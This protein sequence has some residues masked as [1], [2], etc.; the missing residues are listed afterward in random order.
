MTRRVVVLG[1]SHMM[2]IAHAALERPEFRTIQLLDP[3][4]D[5]VLAE[6]QINQAVIDAF[7]AEPFDAVA[8]TLG[9]NEH[10]VLGLV[11][12]P[13]P[14]DFTFVDGEDLGDAAS[15]RERVPVELVRRAIGRMLI[16]SRQFLEKF[17]AL[18]DAPMYLL[19]PPPPIRSDKHLLEYGGVF[20]KEM[21]ARGIAP[22]RLRHK[23]WTLQTDIYADMAA[24]IGVTYLRAPPEA[25]D[26]DGMLAERAWNLDATHANP[27]YGSLVLE[28][29]R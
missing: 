25:I 1:H 2:A 12:H 10:V 5:P 11:E 13:Q 8:L 9:G 16:Y 3:A 19:E 23:L 28:Q 22:P 20:V 24:A 6:G 15:A 17:R 29:L 14:F 27:W 21:E 7:L 26:P 4:F 18:T